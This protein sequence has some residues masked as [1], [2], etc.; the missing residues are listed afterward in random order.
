MKVPLKKGERKTVTGTLTNDQKI[1]LPLV[2][3]F[4]Q[5]GTYVIDN[6]EVKRK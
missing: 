3:G 4:A 5:G 2:I 1:C 6:L